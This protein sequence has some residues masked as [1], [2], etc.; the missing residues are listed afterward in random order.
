M[1]TNDDLAVAA[2]HSVDPGRWL[3]MLDELMLRIGSGFAGWSRGGGR[4]RSC[5]GWWPGGRARNCW[6]IAEHVGDD[7]PGGM[8]HL[9]SRASW[10]ADGV[11]DDL[12][13]YVLERLGDPQAALVVDETGDVKRG[14]ATV[15]V[16]RHYAGICG[17]YVGTAYLRTTLSNPCF[18]ELWAT[19][20][21]L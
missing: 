11:R 5:W 1:Q 17:G 16:Q 21:R 13:A 7:S 12:R 20:S 4:G 14:T 18:P 8:Q 2:G 19:R 3:G 10:D 6:T 15:G 9:M